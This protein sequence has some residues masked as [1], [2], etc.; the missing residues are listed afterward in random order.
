VAAL[1]VFVAGIIADVVVRRA[2]N[3]RATHGASSGAR[4]RKS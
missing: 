4:I 3:L 2:P 1:Q